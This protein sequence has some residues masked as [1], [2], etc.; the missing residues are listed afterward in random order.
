MNLSLSI[1]IDVAGNN[2]DVSNP[3]EVARSVYRTLEKE[4]VGKTSI[5]SQN[6]NLYPFSGKDDFI[7]LEW[8]NRTCL[9]TGAERNLIWPR[10]AN[11]SGDG[12]RAKIGLNLAGGSGDYGQLFKSGEV[13]K[14]DGFYDQLLAVGRLVARGAQ[15]LYSPKACTVTL[16]T[17]PPKVIHAKIGKGTCPY[18]SEAD[19]LVLREFMREDRDLVEKANISAKLQSVLDHTS[20]LIDYSCFGEND[21][22]TRWKDSR[23]KTRT[24]LATFLSDT[25]NSDHGGEDSINVFNLVPQP[26]DHK[27]LIEK[28]TQTGPILVSQ[29]NTSNMQ[30][31]PKRSNPQQDVV[32]SP[33]DGFDVLMQAD[34]HSVG[35]EGVNKCKAIWILAVHA[36]KRDGGCFKPILLGFPV[37]SEGGQ[38]LLQIITDLQISLKLKRFMLKIE[39]E[40]STGLHK[41]L[42]NMTEFTRNI[43]KLNGVVNPSIPF[44]HPQFEIY[45]GIFQRRM[46]S[47]LS[48]SKLP[49]TAWPEAC[50]TINFTSLRDFE[51]AKQCDLLNHSFRGGDYY[52]ERILGDLVYFRPE[53]SQTKL[54]S[55][56][57][58]SRGIPGLAL[59]PRIFTSYQ[60]SV[61]YENDGKMEQTFVDVRSIKSSGEKGFSESMDNLKVLRFLNAPFDTKIL[62]ADIPQVL[63]CDKCQ[64]EGGTHSGAGR[65]RD[66]HTC[67]SGCK[68]RQKHSLKEVSF[69]TEPLHAVE[70][71]SLHVE[72]T[73][74]RASHNNSVPRQTAVDEDVSHGSA[75]YSLSENGK[76]SFPTD[77][78][79]AFFRNFVDSSQNHSLSLIE[80]FE[81]AAADP[82]AAGNE[83]FETMRGSAEPVDAARLFVGLQDTFLHQ[84]YAARADEEKRSLRFGEKDENG[85]WHPYQTDFFSLVITGKEAERL[86]KDPEVGELII[87]GDNKELNALLER[88]VVRFATLSEIELLRSQGVPILIIPSLCVRTLKSKPTRYKSRL[89]ACGNYELSPAQKEDIVTYANTVEPCYFRFLLFLHVQLRGTICSLDVKEAFTQTSAECS[90]KYGTGSRLFLKLPSQWKGQ[91]A[92]SMISKMSPSEMKNQF[93]EVIKSIYGQATAPVCWLQTFCKFLTEKLSFQQSKYDECIFFKCEV[94]DDNTVYVYIAVY[95]DDVWIFSISAYFARR[96]AV[97]ITEEFTSTAISYLC[98]EPEKEWS[99]GVECIFV[100]NQYQI[101]HEGGQVFLRVTQEDY[102][103]N[104]VTKL[105]EKGYV[106]EDAARSSLQ[107]LDQK[108]FVHQFLSQECDSNPLLSSTD[109]TSLR[110]ILNTLAYSTTTRP[111]MAAAI[112]TAARGQAAGRQRHL[113]A[114]RKLIQYA[115]FS[116]DR[117]YKFLVPEISKENVSV[118]ISADF[119]SSLGN[120]GPLIETS[121]PGKEKLKERLEADG[122]ARMG[123]CLFVAAG[124]FDTP[125]EANAAAW[126]FYT[127]SSLSPTVSVGTTEA[128]ITCSSWC[129]RELIAARN[130][131][132]E[133]LPWAQVRQPVA[134][135]DNTAANL[136]AAGQASVRAVRH[137]CLQRLFSRQVCKE[138]LL[139][140]KEKRSAVMT[141]DLLTKVLPPQVVDRLLRLLK[142]S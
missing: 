120:S 43:A 1:V 131:A 68:Y 94:I 37:R 107:V 103:S 122:H 8:G 63:T 82:K 25:P 2:A 129:A 53:K 32:N 141:A 90:Q 45:V 71:C 138:G 108:L 9:D 66:N 46:R 21:L 28:L 127:R 51:G 123:V 132:E 33:P 34:L 70:L 36:R 50:H 47:L 98:G 64:R 95:V 39:R 91:V 112:Q 69:Q 99:E 11:L 110:G 55:N 136:I 109:L 126:C 85:Q 92:P 59:G 18:V 134:F 7:D 105:I 80:L 76:S 104:A 79:S 74:D 72:G 48:F 77:N 44:R 31:A 61:I 27:K 121:G 41:N 16:P 88:G 52:H 86:S 15:F 60:V 30:R 125:V 135:G 83:F 75:F 17:T 118:W 73:L 133:V 40:K 102:V 26:V 97:S 5:F 67:A 62:K 117:G 113:F 10:S 42:T 114:A 12:I 4:A 49:A 96:T 140:V 111:E 58:S 116:R 119:D 38:E 3:L 130:F 139:A 106:E 56:S 124:N 87:E 6:A 35:L 19:T 13:R 29:Q 24:F 54:S 128:E 101:L 115:Y 89:V 78:F 137:L 23:G 65:P 81:N 142:I 20:H 93:L 14:K 100:T 57:A 84:L 22:E